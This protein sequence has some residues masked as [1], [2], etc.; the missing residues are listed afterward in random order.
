MKEGQWKDAIGHLET[1]LK[2]E[3]SLNKCESRIKDELEMCRRELAGRKV[4]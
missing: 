4:E 2:D 1:A 3:G